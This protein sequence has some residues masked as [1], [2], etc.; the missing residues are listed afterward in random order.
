MEHAFNSNTRILKSKQTME[1]MMSYAFV[2]R[3]SKENMK[4]ENWIGNELRYKGRIMTST[5]FL[6]NTIFPPLHEIIGLDK[7]AYI[8]EKGKKR[9]KK[10]RPETLLRQVHIIGGMGAGKSEDA[11]SIVHEA[12]DRYGKK[13]VNIMVSRNLFHLIGNYNPQDNTFTGDRLDNKPIQ[14]IIVD[15]ALSSLAKESTAKKH[16]PQILFNIRHLAKY[17]DRYNNKR[18]LIVLVFTYQ[19]FFELNISA[20]EHVH[21]F[22]FKSALVKKDKSQLKGMLPPEAMQILQNKGASQL[23][24]ATPDRTGVFTMPNHGY[25]SGIWDIPMRPNPYYLKPGSKYYYETAKGSGNSIEMDD[26]EEEMKS[27]SGSDSTGFKDAEIQLD[28]E[29]LE[30]IKMKYPNLKD[31]TI[32]KLKEFQNCIAFN[33]IIEDIFPIDLLEFAFEW[34]KR[35]YSQSKKYDPSKHWEAAYRYLVK[36]ESAGTIAE[37][38]GLTSDSPLTNSYAK[39]GWIAIVITEQIGYWIEQAIPRLDPE[40]GW[41]VVAGTGYSDL[42]DEEAWESKRY[43][44]GSHGEVKARRRKETPAPEWISNQMV[45]HL[46]RGGKAYLYQVIIRRENQQPKPKYVKYR[47]YMDEEKL[48]NA[49]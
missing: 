42:M 17:K 49:I 19:R 5:E 12:I 10:D 44:I 22:I 2:P 4:S 35:N 3:P 29:I 32:T 20:R 14:I 47:V 8:D 27:E 38:F 28:S 25:I 33:V 41:R 31:L 16:L 6:L 11:N 40:I 39:G 45:K 36:G 26:E 24:Q 37:Y 46:L 15:D 18:G 48:Q 13:R 9:Y 23:L 43:G 21:A 34:G 7:V 1:L 30:R